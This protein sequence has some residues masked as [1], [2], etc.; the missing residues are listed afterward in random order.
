MELGE[1]FP[2]VTKLA[3]I[4]FILYIAMEFNL[5]MKYMDVRET[6]LHGDFKDEIYTS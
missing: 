3:F 2:L 6:I 5:E 1:I 4:M